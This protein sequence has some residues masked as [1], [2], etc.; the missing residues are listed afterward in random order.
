[1]VFINFRRIFLTVLFILGAGTLLMGYSGVVGMLFKDQGPGR[2]AAEKSSLVQGGEQREQAP[3]GGLESAGKEGFFV[4][5]RLHRER[6]RGQQIELLREIINSPSSAADTR[7]VAQDQLLSISRSVAKEARVEN[8]LKARGYRDA[9][10]CVDQKGVTVVVESP[11]FNNSEEARLI[12][13][14]SRETGFG[15]QGIIIVPKN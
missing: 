6:T 15:E 14:V 9:V 4:E 10:V 12:E 11:G 1:M 3:V 2:R 5:Y 13:L 8:L 7:Q